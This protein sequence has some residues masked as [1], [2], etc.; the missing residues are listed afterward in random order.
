MPA[1]LSLYPRIA[2]KK[3]PRIL[4]SPVVEMSPF[5]QFKQNLKRRHAHAPYVASANRSANKS[6]A[7]WLWRFLFHYNGEFMTSIL[8][9][10]L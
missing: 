6:I 9:I 7:I 10:N 5:G 1:E 3:M 4:V 8:N 2:G